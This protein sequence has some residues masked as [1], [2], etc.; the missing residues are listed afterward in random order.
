MSND[1]AKHL[2]REIATLD[3]QFVKGKSDR[4]ALNREAVASAQRKSSVRDLN[5]PYSCRWQYENAL[6]PSEAQSSASVDAPLNRRL[7]F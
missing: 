5:S 6:A 7:A 1:A 3:K 2:P 4:P